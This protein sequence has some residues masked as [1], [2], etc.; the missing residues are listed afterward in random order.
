MEVEEDKSHVAVL[1][2]AEKALLSNTMTKLNK[3]FLKEN[4][5]IHFK[6]EKDFSKVFKKDL[7]NYI[8]YLN[9][10]YPHMFVN[11]SSFTTFLKGTQQRRKKDIIDIINYYVTTKDKK[12]N[13]TALVKGT[14]SPH[15][16]NVYIQKEVR[17]VVK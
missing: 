6:N 7:I 13:Y 8:I 17:K 14:S 1:S 11:Q 5:Q 4:G 2:H 16:V 10:Q 3:T 15:L 9:N 12:I